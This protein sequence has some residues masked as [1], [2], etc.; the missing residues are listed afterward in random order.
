MKC[1]SNLLGVGFPR[2]EVDV[3]WDAL[4]SVWSLCP[5]Q[6]PQDED[7]VQDNAPVVSGPTILV[8][9]GTA[10][11]MVPE[12]TAIP[13]LALKIRQDSFASSQSSSGTSSTI[14]Q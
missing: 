10:N 2:F 3:Y 11:A 7:K 8:S 12:S 13:P 5:V 1:F 14:V 4:R 6:L 9:T